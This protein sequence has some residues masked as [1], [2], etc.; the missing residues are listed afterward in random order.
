MALIVCARTEVEKILAASPVAAV[1]SIEHPGA[2]PAKGGAPR[3]SDVPQKILCFW[4]SEMPVANGPDMDQV[5]AGIAFVMEHAL[6]GDVI[7]H[8]NAGKARSAALALG[9]LAILHPR[10]DEGQLIDRLLAQ[11]PQAAPNIL[12]LLLADRI[13]GREGKLLQAVLDHPGMTAAR[14]ATE[15]RRQELLKADPDLAQKLFPEKFANK[16]PNAPEM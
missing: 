6:D 5:E 12:V 10:E 11:R 1:L 8:C 13:A 4:D 16:K 2:T 15:A 7:I 14:A 9:V 3:L